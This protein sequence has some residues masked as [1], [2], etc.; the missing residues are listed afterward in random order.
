MRLDHTG[1][2]LV[3]A[4]YS[5]KEYFN[6]SNSILKF[7]SA[8]EWNDSLPNTEMNHS[9]KYEFGYVAHIKHANML[10]CILCNLNNCEQLWH[11]IFYK[12]C[13]AINGPDFFC[14]DMSS[15]SFDVLLE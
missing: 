11:I 13:N 14:F 8:T 1:K 6:H 9:C 5:A 10:L 7:F 3:K 4:S 2:Y 12:D 15:C